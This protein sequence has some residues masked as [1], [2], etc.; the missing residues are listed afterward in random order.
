MPSIL[1]APLNLLA[2]GALVHTFAAGTSSIAVDGHGVLYASG[3]DINGNGLIS[4]FNPATNIAGTL[5]PEAAA[6]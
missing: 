6:R 2:D 4:Y 1:H 5:N 3:Y